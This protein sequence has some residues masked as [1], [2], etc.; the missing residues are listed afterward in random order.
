MQARHIF[1][2]RFR[3]NV[4]ILFSCRSLITKAEARG[5]HKQPL[6]SGTTTLGDLINW[7]KNER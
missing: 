1:L 2:L 4:E 5:G 6:S 7:R 3:R